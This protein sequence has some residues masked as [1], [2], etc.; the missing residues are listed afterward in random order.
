MRRSGTSHSI[1][2][3]KPSF[4]VSLLGL[5]AWE[6][7][8]SSAAPVV[9][10]VRA[11]QRAGTRL[12]D[13]LYDVS[14]ADGDSPLTVSF[15]V[16]ADGGATWTVPVFTFQ[17]AGPGVVPGNNRSIVWSAAVDW[18]GEF[19]NNCRVRVCADDGK[20]ATPSGMALI[21][22][23]SFVMGDTLSMTW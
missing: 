14:D 23:G 11:A 12:V 17:G 8:L 18:S 21:P 2:A 6:V 1:A 10:N 5:L 13:I 15:Q 19:N 22:A 3:M 20:T 9:S 4:V 16:S 7:S